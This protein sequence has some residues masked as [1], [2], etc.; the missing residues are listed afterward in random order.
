MAKAYLSPAILKL[1]G[2]W[3]DVLFRNSPHGPQVVAHPPKQA[4]PTAPQKDQHDAFRTCCT[5]WSLL[6]SI[7]RDDW[8]YFCTSHGYHTFRMWLHHALPREAGIL[9]AEPIPDSDEPAVITNLAAAPGANPGEIQLTWDFDG[10]GY[11]YVAVFD[12][13]ERPAGDPLGDPFWAR[14][15]FAP[16]LADFESATLTGLKPG[17]QYWLFA[18]PYGIY[19]TH[20]GSSLG[21]PAIAK[22]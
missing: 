6:P 7:Y 4:S 16:V 9:P 2:K 20:F 1:A 12:L 19:S 14:S 17:Q 13:R 21:R 22:S 11:S 5:L 15:F 3:A 18:T 10:P 8:E